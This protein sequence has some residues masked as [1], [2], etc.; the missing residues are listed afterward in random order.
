MM[1]SYQNALKNLSSYYIFVLIMENV[2]Q[3]YVKKIDFVTEAQR[4]WQASSDFR[5]RRERCKRYCY[6][7]QWG[8]WV[9][10]EGKWVKE[11][12]YIRSMGSEPLKNNLI[13]RLVKQVLGLFRHEMSVMK[14]E[15]DSS[16]FPGHPALADAYRQM[17]QLN[18][19]DEMNARA[20]EEFLISG[21]VVQRKTYGTRQGVRGCFTDN[22]SPSRLIID[23]AFRDTRGWDVRCVGEIHDMS[24][25]MLCAEFAHDAADF[26]RL[27]DIY[28]PSTYE[29]RVAQM[30]GHYD[31]V[32]SADQA[33]LTPFSPNSCRV[34]ELWRRE[35][36]PG[37]LCHDVALGELFWV[38][39][40]T[41]PLVD[42][43][44]SLRKCGMPGAVMH[45]DE[46]PPIQMYWMMTDEWR[47][48]YLTP[49]GD[50]L[51]E[52]RSPFAHRQHPYVF[53]AYPFVDGE[54]HSFVD[55]V[56]DQQRYTN[57]LITLYDWVM[58][59]SAKGVLL[60]PEE[61]I[62]DGYTIDDVAAQWS[63]FNGVIPVRTRNG[64]VFPQQVSANAVNIGINELLNTQLGFM[65][66]ISGVTGALQGKTMG[67][68]MSGKLYE[69]Q[70]RNASLSQLDLL[71]SFYGFLEEAKRKDLSNLRQF[72]VH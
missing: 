10:A 12:Q 41:A 4:Y 71:D 72:V 26:S 53:K 63:R 69:Q 8:D 47:Y 54:I 56:I 9:M 68:S 50:V 42:A 48:Y 43:V 37:Y 61:S 39:A 18:D 60:V 24:Y 55:D 21:L 11:E 57:R 67:T 20:L 19:M 49:F 30:L 1:Q 13:R 32:R 66:D 44:N 58:R 29:E 25:D 70:T 62:P 14:N 16:G 65:E 22:V 64:A 46:M 15:R 38:D 34:Y 31:A 40:S 17:C 28:N 51:D 45:S 23:T 5:L 7:D 59:S 3:Q 33:F 52:G 36:R 2:I 6:G 27:A 35:R